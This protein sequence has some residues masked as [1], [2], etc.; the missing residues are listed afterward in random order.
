MKEK[1]YKSSIEDASIM[2]KF[3]ILFLVMSMI[4][5]GVLYFFY[6]DIEKHGRLQISQS[7]YNMAL[8]FIVLGISIGYLAMR[9]VLK[10]IILLVSTSR[11]I[12]ENVLDPE[13]LKEIDQNS[14]EIS[15][16]T[17]SF[18]AIT[19]RLEEN[20]R[21]LELAKKTLHSVLF[22][23]GNGI[24]NMQNI[25]SFL[26]LIVETVTEAL[27]CRIGVLLLLSDDKKVLS[28]KTVHGKE[29]DFSKNVDIRIHP[30][31]PLQSLITTKQPVIIKERVAELLEQSVHEKLF[32]SPLLCAPLINNEKVSGVLII[33]G[34]KDKEAFNKDEL[35]LLTNLAA[36]TAV[37]IKNS[38]LSKDI[39]KTYFETVSALAL[40]VD[41]KD[42]YSRGHLDR[43]ADYSIIIADK[44]GLDEDDKKTLRAAARLHDVGK[45]GIPDKVLSK[46]GK[47]SES[48]W[49]LMRKHP[50]IGESIIKPVRSLRYLCDIVRHHHEKLD[51][52]GYPDG[53]K[54]DEITP[55][56]RITTVADI[57]DALTTDR[58]Y[59]EKMSRQKA[60][61]I[62]RDMHEQLD[63]DIVEVFVEA[64]E[65]SGYKKPGLAEE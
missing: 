55:L 64:L 26:E 25:D 35:N 31:S 57:Y 56:V 18:S 7:S 39:E 47:L 6:L 32:V 33:S 52:T 48:E 53:L 40:A 27:N 37:A 28:L 11:D 49:A 50:E 20:I 42:K 9:A 65:E 4:P 2:R 19:Q 13:I 16:L 45:I 63:P 36:Q 61:A 12:L 60:F 62:L 43:V 3:T 10:K 17:K 38:Q 15:A 8:I 54:R 59:R 24:S 14:N 23:V 5:T 58:S 22:K 29:Y 44:L 51:G 41:A 21:N 34:R 1:G 30:D 46:P